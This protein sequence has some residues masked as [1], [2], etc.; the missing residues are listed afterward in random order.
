MR[1][2]IKSSN[3]LL[4]CKIPFQVRKK[5]K[6]GKD[7]RRKKKINFEALLFRARQREETRLKRKE[8]PP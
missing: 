3:R 1:V 7:R 6:R 2:T 5:R 8:A 4:H